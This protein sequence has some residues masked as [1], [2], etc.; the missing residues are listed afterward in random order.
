[1]RYH[2]QRAR[3]CAVG[4][5][6][7]LQHSLHTLKRELPVRAGHRSQQPGHSAPLQ[8]QRRP[9]KLSPAEVASLAVHSTYCTKPPQHEASQ[10]KPGATHTHLSNA[11]VW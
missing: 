5:A 3:S 9:C 10:T 6:Q 4:R 1:M 11:T 7:Q 8:R 2:G